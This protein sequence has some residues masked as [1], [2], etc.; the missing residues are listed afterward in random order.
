MG[1]GTYS[2]A[3]TTCIGTTCGTFSGKA[4]IQDVLV[5]VNYRF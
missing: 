5:G 4:D 1:F 3:V 2:N